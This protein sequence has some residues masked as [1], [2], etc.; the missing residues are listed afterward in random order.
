MGR[1]SSDR[2]TLFYNIFG[3]GYGSGREGGREEKRSAEREFLLATPGLPDVF[4]C[5]LVLGY[6]IY[7]RKYVYRMRRCRGGFSLLVL[8]RPLLKVFSMYS[9]EG[10]QT[11]E[12]SC[13]PNAAPCVTDSEISCPYTNCV[14]CR[15]CPPAPAP[16]HEPR[17]FVLRREVSPQN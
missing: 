16:G 3:N 1:F 13:G 4:V 5:R 7:R 10:L 9:P 2:P 14:S 6:V 11:R 8:Y 12:E 17:F 15:Y